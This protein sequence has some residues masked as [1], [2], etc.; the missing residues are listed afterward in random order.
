MRRSARMAKR[1]DRA[2]MGSNESRK[3]R[4]ASAKLLATAILNGATHDDHVAA[5]GARAFSPQAF[6][7]MRTQVLAW[8]AR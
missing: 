6:A 5:F 2:R 7:N 8:S 1:A 4:D 3:C